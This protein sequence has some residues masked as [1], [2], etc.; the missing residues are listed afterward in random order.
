MPQIETL[1]AYCND[2][3]RASEYNKQLH[4]DSILISHHPDYTH[5]PPNLPPQSWNFQ[6]IK[7]SP[8]KPPLPLRN[9]L[10]ASTSIFYM[11]VNIVFVVGALPGLPGWWLSSNYRE[12]PVPTVPPEDRTPPPSSAL[13]HIQAKSSD[14]RFLAVRDIISYNAEHSTG[15]CT[16]QLPWFEKRA[17]NRTMMEINVGKVDSQGVPSPQSHVSHFIPQNW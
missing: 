10:M 17:R 15:K 5:K 16:R 7:C 6:G 12:Q 4:S 3:P 13:P 14:K 8:A 11:P 9:T 1:L 2:R